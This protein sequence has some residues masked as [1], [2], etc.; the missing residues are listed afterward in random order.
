MGE[1]KYGQYIITDIKPKKEAPWAPKFKPDE[2]IPMLYLDSSVVKGAFYVETAWTLPAFA[3]ETHGESH[4]HDYDEVLAFFGSNPESPQDLNAE[5]DV[6]LGG[7]IHKVTK[8]CL[9]FIPKGVQHGPI[10]FNRIDRPIF[11]FSCGT[12]SKYF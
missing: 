4:R 6:H 11:H 3:N 9:I 1:T 10:V 5:A 7:E 2:L 8:S 12:S